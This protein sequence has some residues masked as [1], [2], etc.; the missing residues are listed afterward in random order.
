MA[1]ALRRGILQVYKLKTI[2]NKASDHKKPTNESIFT[3]V[4]IDIEIPM[5]LEFIMSVAE[6]S[7]RPVCIPGL[8]HSAYKFQSLC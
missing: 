1:E 6:F 7:C 2:R 3:S 8:P 5:Y 4:A